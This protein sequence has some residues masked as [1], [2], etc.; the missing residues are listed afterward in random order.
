MNYDVRLEQLY[1]FPPERVWHALTD[2]AALAQWLMPND[3]VPRIGHRFQFRSTPMPGWRGFVQCEVIKLEPPRKL[4]YTWIGDDDWVE[5]SIVQWTLEP[6]GTGTLLRLEHTGLQEPWGRELQAMLQQGWKKMLE[7][8]L[9][10]VVAQWTDQP[11][12]VQEVSPD[13]AEG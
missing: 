10:E 11:G 8:K 7:K 1:P 4:A 12:P 13:G 9:P 6:R 5:P 2:S 3:F